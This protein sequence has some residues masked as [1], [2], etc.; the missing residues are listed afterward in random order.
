M[1]EQEDSTNLGRHFTYSFS[2]ICFDNL[3]LS[4]I[5]LPPLDEKIGGVIL[6]FATMITVFQRDV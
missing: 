2:T 5:A 6:T 4:V 1:T 3:F